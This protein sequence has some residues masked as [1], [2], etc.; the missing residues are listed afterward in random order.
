MTSSAKRKSPWLQAQV[1]PLVN[2][3]TDH[4]ASRWLDGEGECFKKGVVMEEV[5]SCPRQEK[6]RTDEPSKQQEQARSGNSDENLDRHMQLHVV[7]QPKLVCT[8]SW[9]N[10][11]FSTK[12]DLI[13]HV[14]DCRFFCHLCGRVIKKT[15]RD[16]GHLKLCSKRS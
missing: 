4:E 1:A 3:D 7:Q 6:C 14:K 15:G 10:T 2:A 5:S 11:P 9:C 8:K 13:N 12:F 16:K